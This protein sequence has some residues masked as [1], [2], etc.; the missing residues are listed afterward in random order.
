MSSKFIKKKSNFYCKIILFLL[1][2]ISVF[3]IYIYRNANKIII[4]IFAGRKQHLEILL[5]YLKY[6]KYHK[7]ISEIHFWQFTSNKESE[8]YLSSLSNL[9]KTNG[10]FS[11]YRNIYPLIYNNNY[12]VIRIN[13]QKNGACLLINKK[14]EI[15][16]NLHEKKD[17]IISLKISNNIY[18]GKQTD[19]YKKNIYITYKIKI[20]DYHIIIEDKKNV[21]IKSIIDDNHF[22]SIKIKSQIN[23]ET[24]W[25][26]EESINKDMKLYDT[27]F[28]KRPHWYET[29]N[30]Y[31]NYNFDILI[32]LD[33]DICFVDINRFDEFI[34]FIKS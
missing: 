25:D 30:F 1:L 29:Y 24:I 16:F 8:Q 10:K 4:V 23:A 27:K 20:I 31:L 14:F 32:K 18:Y 21:L 7:K 2:I 5:R 12:F 22:D 17:I 28:R 6:L 3:Y 13:F 9:H 15:I 11:Y 19:I 26:Y 34:T 33:D